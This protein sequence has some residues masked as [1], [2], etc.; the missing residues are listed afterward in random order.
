ME[1]QVMRVCEIYSK[2]LVVLI[3]RYLKKYGV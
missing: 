1:E 3:F 2:L